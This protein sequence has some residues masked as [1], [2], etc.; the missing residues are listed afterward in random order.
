VWLEH[1]AYFVD[2]IGLWPSLAREC[3]TL[4]LKSSRAF[5]LNPVDLNPIR[6]GLIIFPPPPK[7]L[8]VSPRLTAELEKTVIMLTVNLKFDTRMAY[9]SIASFHGNSSIDSLLVKLDSEILRK[10]KG[11][12]M[13]P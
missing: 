12:S 11:G 5:S 8:M 3:L 13:G 7:S 6:E 10:R 4:G 9:T 1:T 2:A